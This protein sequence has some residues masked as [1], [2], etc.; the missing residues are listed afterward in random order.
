[1]RSFFTCHRPRTVMSLSY[2]YKSIKEVK[3]RLHSYKVNKCL[4][5]YKAQ[6]LFLIIEP[7][8]CINFSKFLFW[9][10]TIHVSDN[11]AVHHQEFSDVHTAMVYVIQVCCQLCEQEHLLLLTSC[12]QTCM[13]YTIAVYTVENS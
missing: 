6:L 1:M 5:Q 10:E 2:K 7:T 4:T 11:S 8:K 13:T 3:N 9:N 12:Q